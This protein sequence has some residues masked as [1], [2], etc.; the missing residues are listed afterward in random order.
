MFFEGLHTDAARTI[1]IG[2]V[3]SQKENFV[4]S[5]YGIP[6]PVAAFEEYLTVLN[7]V[8]ENDKRRLNYYKEKGSRLPASVNQVQQSYNTRCKS[9]N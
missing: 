3:S 7:K 6:Y 9:F 5:A 1:K 2:E 8:C 4:S